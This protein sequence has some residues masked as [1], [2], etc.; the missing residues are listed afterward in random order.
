MELREVGESCRF[1]LAQLT[2]AAERW[3]RARATAAGEA[4]EQRHFDHNR[5]TEVLH[6]QGEQQT[7][8]FD[9]LESALATWAR[10]SMII[11]PVET[12]G[13]PSAFRRNRGAHIRA[14]LRLGSANIIGDRELRDSWVHFDE[15]LDQVVQQGRWGNRHQFTTQAEIEAGKAK[16]IRLFALDTL[17]IYY[18]RRTGQRSSQTIASMQASLD[19]IIGNLGS[20]WQ[21]LRAGPPVVD[22]DGA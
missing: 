10:A 16:G 9:A 13:E 12:G 6:R 11:Y 17:T 5:F 22:E 19:E 14:L 20:A 2:R 1:H 18:L 8:A 21:T 4:S 15:R 3:S 7:L